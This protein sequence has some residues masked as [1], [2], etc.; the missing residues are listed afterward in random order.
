[1][2]HRVPTRIRFFSLL[3]MILAGATCTSPRIRAENK[4]AGADIWVTVASAPIVR[5]PRWK[6][7]RTDAADELK[8]E[9]PWKTVAAR[10][11]VAKLIAGNIENTR[12]ADLQA[13]IEEVKRHHFELAL[14]IGPLVRSTNCQ[15]K[16]EAYGAPGET[17]AILKK[18][19]RNGGEL[20]YIAMDEPFFYGHRDAGGC[21]LSADQ[22]AQKVAKSVASMRQIFPQLQI[23]DIEVTNADRE[24][25]GELAQWVDAYCAAVGEPLAF[26][27]ADVDWSELAM[28]NL[29]PLAAELKQRRIPFG[30]IYNADGNVTSDLEW[31]QSAERHFVE[32]ESVLN[33]HPDAA[34]FQTWTRYPTN[35]L[36]ESQPGTLMNVA[37]QYLQPAPSLR[38]T[39]SGA[40]INGVLDRMNGGPIANAS[41]T[42]TAV[43]VGARI[44]PT[45]RHWASTVPAE[46]A[47]AVIGIRVGMEGSCVCGGATGAIVGGIHYKEQGSDKLQEAIS[48]VSLPIQGA[49]LSVRTLEL[50]PGKTYSPNL[51]QFPV[52]AG[53]AFTLDTSIAATAAAEDAGYVTIVFLDAAGKGLRRDNIWFTPA[54]QV[55]GT[56]QTDAR[57]EFRLPLPEAEVLAQP[58]I[59]AEYAGNASLRPAMEVL[60][61]SLGAMNGSL[62][63][64]ANTLPRPAPNVE[65]SKQVWFSPRQDFLELLKNGASW[66]EVEKQWS[67]GAKRV[68][69]VS[70]T[71]G[72]I[73]SLPDEVLARMV[74]DLD[75][76]HIALGLGILPTNWFHEPPCGGGVEGFSDPGSANQTVAKLMKAGASVSIID[77]DEPLW[78]GHFYNGKNACKSSLQELGQR[79]AVIAKIYTA[80]FP[81]AIV[82]DTEPFP[83]ISSQQNWEAAF[84]SWVKTFQAE[85]GTRLSFLHLDFNWGDPRLNTGPQDNIPNPQAIV[86]LARTTMSVARANDLQ[87]GIIYWGG[88]TG[89]IEWMDRARAHINDIRAGGIKPDHIIFVSWNKYPARTLPETDPLALTSLIMYYF[90]HHK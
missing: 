74:R 17:E 52:T 5:D 54:T 42:L 76:E 67:D 34:I 79:V 82:G 37:L 25:V 89:D 2:E 4:K 32:I 18:I 19:R 28:R 84:A 50:A 88:G 27:H 6:G 73:R 60:P 36:P 38:L 53:A 58:E 80:A 66:D 69:V 49:P 23:G 61:S 26:L 65:N 10:A 31:T 81:N 43:D 40:E 63:E 16:T 75:R 11:Q 8:L 21:R 86:A 35:V 14:E 90:E 47:T 15:P 71:E 39:R 59:R 29:V 24:W 44:G 62:P 1:M 33:V 22:L 48:P 57:G 70:F 12:D 83:A 13:A 55:L 45:L 9:A 20:R 41:I 72:T 64:L 46:A 68:N 56:V 3:A 87:A 30:I 85:T 77:M 7:I 78:F 51:K